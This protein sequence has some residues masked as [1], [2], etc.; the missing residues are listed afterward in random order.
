MDMYGI[1]VTTAVASRD[2]YLI[3]ELKDQ[4]EHEHQTTRSELLGHALNHA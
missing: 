3:S 2:E 4:L 1:I